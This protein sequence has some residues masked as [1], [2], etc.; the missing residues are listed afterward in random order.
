MFNI[1]SHKGNAN[2]NDAEIPPHPVQ[3]GNYQQLARKQ[4]TTNEDTG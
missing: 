2:Q 4:T 1:L 3:N